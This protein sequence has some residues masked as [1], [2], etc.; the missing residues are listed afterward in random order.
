M[1]HSPHPHTQGNPYHLPPA[2]RST[3]PRF[4]SNSP[5]AGQAYAGSSASFSN[6]GAQMSPDES[7][8]DYA[9]LWSTS[10]AGGGA[11]GGQPASNAGRANGKGK[12][13]SI[14]VKNDL[15]EDD[16]GASE[17]DTADGQPSGGGAGGEG[18]E[19][20]GGEVK[21]KSTRGSR[22]CQVCRKLKMRC[23]GAEDP[24][25][26]RCRTQGHEVSPLLSL[27]QSAG[28]APQAGL[29]GCWHASAISLD[30]VAVR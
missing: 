6:G 14:K 7:E 2:A 30:T 16:F 15:D 9:Q 20:E 8:Q 22:A 21:K 4:F 26:K 29:F 24:P 19:P 13:A 12:A 11:A 1:S 17:N 28:N 3:D 25:C 18:G 5:Q 27:F 23:V 10:A